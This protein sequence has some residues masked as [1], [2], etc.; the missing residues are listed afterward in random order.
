MCD[1]LIQWEDIVFNRLM[2]E[3]TAEIFCSLAEVVSKTSNK[4]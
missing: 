2:H 1:V 3:Q 4:T